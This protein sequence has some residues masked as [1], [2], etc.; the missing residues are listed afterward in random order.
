MIEE[1]PLPKISISWHIQSLY[2]RE[3]G[4]IFWEIHRCWNDIL[5]WRENGE[6][7]YLNEGKNRKKKII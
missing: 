7:Y 6:K 5:Y 1:T 3:F 4:E 2:K